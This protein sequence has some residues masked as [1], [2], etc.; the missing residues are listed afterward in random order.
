MI[1]YTFH[2]WLPRV[3]GAFECQ[4]RNRYDN[5]EEF[6]VVTKERAQS[7]LSRSTEEIHKKAEKAGPMI[8]IPQSIKISIPQSI[9][10]CLYIIDSPIDIDVHPLPMMD[11]ILGWILD[12]HRISS[13]PELYLFIIF[14]IITSHLKIPVS[15]VSTILLIPL[16]I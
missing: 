14:Y 9:P 12:H 2:K 3:F 11:V 7:E 15:K 5:A 8:S 1:L 4:R 13:V 6:L 16:P 10:G